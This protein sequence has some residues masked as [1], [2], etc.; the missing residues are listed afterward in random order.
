MYIGALV[1][2]MIFIDRKAR[3]IMHLVASVSPFVC[4]CSHGLTV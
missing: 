2:R 3:E 1:I 4:L